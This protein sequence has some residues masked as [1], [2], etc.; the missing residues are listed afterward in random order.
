LTNFHNQDGVIPFDDHL[1]GL[2]L[3][4]LAEIS[5]LEVHSPHISR[6]AFLFWIVDTRLF[7]EILCANTKVL[8]I[9][10]VIFLDHGSVS[11]LIRFDSL[12]AAGAPGQ[13]QAEYQVDTS[14]RARV[15]HISLLEIILY[16][17]CPLVNDYI[18]YKS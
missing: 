10:L 1:A 17:T 4:R 13:Q 11:I 8:E 18:I 14:D 16:K 9:H 2:D 5:F 12:L 3:N 6:Q 15:E 7:L